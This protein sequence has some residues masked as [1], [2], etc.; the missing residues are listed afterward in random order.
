MDIKVKNFSYKSPS[1]I[2][3]RVFSEGLRTDNIYLLSSEESPDD[4]IVEI[5]TTAIVGPATGRSIWV[6]QVN[7]HPWSQIIAEYIWEHLDDDEVTE[8][9]FEP[10]EIDCSK[11]G[12][13]CGIK[14]QI[15][16]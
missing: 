2:A 15:S 7:P 11:N 3:R 16:Y 13:F 5:D 1:A 8:E 9:T 10:Y 4:P 14:V 12:W 6:I